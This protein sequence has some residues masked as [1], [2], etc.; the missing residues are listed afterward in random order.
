[1]QNRAKIDGIKILLVRDVLARILCFVLR[2]C[3]YSNRRSYARE[4]M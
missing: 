3:K 4:A 2:T 1:M